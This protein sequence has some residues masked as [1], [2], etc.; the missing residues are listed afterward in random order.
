MKILRVAGCLMI[1][2]GL[3]LVMLFLSGLGDTWLDEN[4]TCSSGRGV[5][6]ERECG[7]FEAKWSALVLSAVIAFGGVIV[8]LIP[9]MRHGEP[10]ST[11]ALA[12]IDLRFL[13][14]RLRRRR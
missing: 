13:T 1:V 4:W 10:G 11:K 14:R 3:A 5:P 2:G 12:T 7:L 6:R 8:A 9:T